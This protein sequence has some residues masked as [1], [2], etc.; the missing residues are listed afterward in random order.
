MNPPLSPMTHNSFQSTS[1]KALTR[2]AS[3]IFSFT[4]KTNIENLELEESGAT[5]ASTKKLLLPNLLGL[6]F[7]VKGEIK[8]KRKETFTSV[9]R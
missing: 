9:R 1:D 7:Y 6:C 5:S 2:T 4:Q 8:H 3:F